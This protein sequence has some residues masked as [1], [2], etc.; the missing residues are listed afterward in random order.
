MFVMLHIG[1]D[2]IE[3]LPGEGSQARIA[4]MQCALG[5]L[6]KRS[7]GFHVEHAWHHERDSHGFA[8]LLASSAGRSR[9]PVTR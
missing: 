9:D 5:H 8:T 4:P 2:C 6:L 1:A 7:E 3:V